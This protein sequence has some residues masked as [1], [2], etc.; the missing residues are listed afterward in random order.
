MQVYKKKIKRAKKQERKGLRAEEGEEDSDEEEEEEEES[1]DDLRW[2]S[3]SA[4]FAVWIYRHY[5]GNAWS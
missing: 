2:G 3:P 1:D 5:V 4:I